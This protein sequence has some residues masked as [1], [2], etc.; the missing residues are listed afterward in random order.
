MTKTTNTTPFIATTVLAATVAVAALIMAVRANRPQVGVIDFMKVHKNAL[1]YQD[2]AAKQQQYDEKLQA[3]ILQDKEF[4]KLQNDGK[5]LEENQK[6]MDKADF[7]KKAKALEMK[8][9]KINE[10]FRPDF[11]RNMMASQ[12]ALKGIQQQIAEAIEAT[13]EATGAKVLLPVNNI[14]YAGEKADLTDAFIEELNERVQ[15]VTY[16]D[17][18]TL[19]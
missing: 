17:P 3:T 12:L 1:A 15:T 9:I 11:E 14:L 7:A 10:R 2:A 8:A 13:S 19:K 5:K 4:L 18:A 16:P 6:A